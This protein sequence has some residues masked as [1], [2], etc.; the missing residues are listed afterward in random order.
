MKLTASLLTLSVLPLINSVTV[1]TS[2]ITS[3]PSNAE[4]DRLLSRRTAIPPPEL[5]GH[6]RAGPSNAAS[7][8]SFSKRTAILP[9]EYLTSIRTGP[10]NAA[11]DE[12]THN[13]RKR[14]YY[15]NWT[16]RVSRNRFSSNVGHDGMSCL[17][18][19]NTTKTSERSLRFPRDG[20]N[21]LTE[22]LPICIYTWECH[23]T[24]VAMRRRH[25]EVCKREDTPEQVANYPKAILEGKIQDQR[26]FNIGK[27]VAT[28]YNNC[29]DTEEELVERM[30]K[31]SKEL[32]WKPELTIE[33]AYRGLHAMNPEMYPYASYEEKLKGGKTP[34][35]DELDSDD[36]DLFGRPFPEWVDG[37]PVEKPTQPTGETA[38][39]TDTGTDKGVPVVDDSEQDVEDGE[40]SEGIPDLPVDPKE[41][42]KGKT[43]A[44][45]PTQEGVNERCKK[46]Y[47]ASEADS[48]WSIAK[49]NR[50]SVRMLYRWNPAVNTDGE[51]TWLWIGYAYCVKA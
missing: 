29:P 26:W 38:G 30:L 36:T 27:A 33:E 9:P 50:I 46:W 1:P 24:G 42:P 28:R 8:H 11:T 5:L 3:G 19:E 49:K 32:G 12:S 25:S 34:V 20:M 22:N 6:L 47:L 39:E 41:K 18:T 31:V 37:K 14:G 17:P 16:F 43:P 4:S 51:C 15:S 40:N 10:S 35:F 48:C 45:G 2:D 7:D 23:G 13:L 21:G 44:P